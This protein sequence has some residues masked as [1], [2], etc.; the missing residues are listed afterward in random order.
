MRY[1]NIIN[2]TNQI[3]NYFQINLNNEINLSFISFY[4]L[5]FTD[6][7]CLNKTAGRYF[8]TLIDNKYKIPHDNTS[9]NMYKSLF[10]F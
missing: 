4:F 1:S 6:I 7:I 3:L 2:F 5:R 8:L 9:T 10:M